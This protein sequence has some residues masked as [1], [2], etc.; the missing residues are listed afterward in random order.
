MVGPK[1]FYLGYK[2]LMQLF[3]RITPFGI[4]PCGPFTLKLLAGLD[5]FI[6]RFVAPAVPPAKMIDRSVHDNAGKPGAEPGLG[7]EAM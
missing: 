4:S 7:T 5:L 2:Q 1:L 6:Q 3:S